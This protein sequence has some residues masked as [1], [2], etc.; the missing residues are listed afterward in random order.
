MKEADEA[1]IRVADKVRRY[2]TLVDFGSS[3]SIGPLAIRFT[4]HDK[5]PRRWTVN[6]EMPWEHTK[7]E[8]PTFESVLAELETKIEQD[9]RDRLREA[10]TFIQALEEWNT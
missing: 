8:G 6:V 10:R 2:R 7:A 4:Y 3:V 9:V 1:V 5:A